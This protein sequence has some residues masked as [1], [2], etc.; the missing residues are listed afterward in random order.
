MADGKWIMT[1]E[2]SRRVDLTFRGTA[3]QDLRSLPNYGQHKQV[4]D[5]EGSEYSL[6]RDGYR[7]LFQ[8]NGH[9]VMEDI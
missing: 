5:R 7:P 6:G 8:E 1:E 3:R 4:D 9:H 2:D